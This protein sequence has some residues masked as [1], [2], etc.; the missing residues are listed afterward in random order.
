MSIYD[1]DFKTRMDYY[2][3]LLDQDDLIPLRKHEKL[4]MTLALNVLNQMRKDIADMR[5]EI[6]EAFLIIQNLEVLEELDIQIKRNYD[7][8]LKNN[9]DIVNWM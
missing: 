9:A 5:A 4:P 8:L 2:L 3:M 6:R 1:E 7:A